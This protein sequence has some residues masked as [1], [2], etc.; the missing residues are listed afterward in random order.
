MEEENKRIRKY[1]RQQAKS[2]FRR[3]HTRKI[4][5]AVARHVLEVQHINHHAF[6]YKWREIA[7]MI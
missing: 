3:I 7:S 6:R 1:A 2:Q 5:R 4:D